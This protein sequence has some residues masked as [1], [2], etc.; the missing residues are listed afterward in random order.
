MTVKMW[1]ID[2]RLECCARVEFCTM[3]REG[4]VVAMYLC[5]DHKH[6]SK[7]QP[8]SVVDVQVMIHNR[9]LYQQTVNACCQVAMTGSKVLLYVSDAQ[10][11]FKISTIKCYPHTNHNPNRKS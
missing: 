6:L 10:I 4:V 3:S 9:I 1:K 2:C 8:S 11:A 7:F 5:D